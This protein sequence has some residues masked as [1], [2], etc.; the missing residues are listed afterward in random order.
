MKR[1][2]HRGDREMSHIY[3]ENE[4]EKKRGRKRDKKGK[5]ERRG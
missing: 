5:R 1:E 4:R 3:R 2:K